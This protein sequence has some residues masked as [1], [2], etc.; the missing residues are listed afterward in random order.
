MAGSVGAGNAP[1]TGGTF[2]AAGGG[3]MGGYATGGYGGFNQPGVCG[4]GV[5]E[6]MEQCDDSNADDGDGCSSMCE[7]E[8]GYVCNW[9]YDAWGVPTMTCEPVSCGDGRQDGYLLE[10]GSYFYESCDDG[11]AV[12]GDGCSESCQLDPG[13]V[14]SQPGTPCREAVCGDGLQD[15]WYTP[16]QPGTG[17]VGAGG[18]AA[19]A[20]SGGYAGTGGYGNQIYH[21]EACDDGNAVPG[22]GCSDTCEVE[23]GY[24]CQQP[25][26]PCR[27]PRCGDGYVDF[28]SGP[29]GSG[30]GGFGGGG[31]T[32]EGCDDGNVSTGDGCDTTCQVED[33]WSCWYTGENPCHRIVCGDGLVDYPEQCDDGNHAP[34]DGCD[35]CVWLGGYAGGAGT[36]W[37]SSG[38]PGA[39]GFAGIGGAGPNGGV[40]NGG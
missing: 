21:F 17:G 33:G 10:D 12:S 1:G 2:G 3:A 8:P 29:G 31:G 11:N 32:Y 13:W 22:D 28:I 4:N 15:S 25:G 38:A 26:T 30:S 20:G 27:I 5:T 40:A 18:F 16:G 23:A 6:W 7:L 19:Y 14:C 9:E 35:E 24:L 36:G 39:G 37:G 34:N